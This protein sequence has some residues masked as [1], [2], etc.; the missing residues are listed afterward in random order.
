M[1]IVFVSGVVQLN[2]TIPEKRSRSKENF[3]NKMR[4]KSLEKMMYLLH[5]IFLFFIFYYTVVDVV[6]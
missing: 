4:F 6:Q 3:E 5:E 1:R 2:K